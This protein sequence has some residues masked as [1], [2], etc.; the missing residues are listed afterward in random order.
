M[1]RKLVYGLTEIQEKNEG[2]FKGYAQGKNVKN[3]FPNSESKAKGI[4]KII[5]SNVCGPM[6]F[7]AL[8]GYGYYISFIDDF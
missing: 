6:S 3:T 1:A 4:L 7:S 2:I 5:H 8:R